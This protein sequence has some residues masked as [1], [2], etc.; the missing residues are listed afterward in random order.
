MVL[1]QEEKK[2]LKILKR[3]ARGSKIKVTKVGTI[4]KVRFKGR[5]M[6][7]VRQITSNVASVSP[8]AQLRAMVRLSKRK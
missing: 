5:G 1:T 6:N 7:T 4:G 3:I 8:Q 2:K